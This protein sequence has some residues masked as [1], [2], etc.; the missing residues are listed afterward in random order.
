MNT[1]DIDAYCTCLQDELTSPLDRYFL[2]SLVVLVP[3][4]YPCDEQSLWKLVI[5]E[6]YKDDTTSR[7]ETIRTDR[8][9]LKET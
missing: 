4:R 7:W 9:K 3:G 6:V 2:F 5:E 8:N 1:I